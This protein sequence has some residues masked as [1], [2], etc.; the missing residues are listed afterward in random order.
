[1]SRWRATYRGD[2]LGWYD[3]AAEADSAIDNEAQR[4]RTEEEIY[5]WRD[6]CDSGREE[7][8]YGGRR[9]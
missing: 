7:V 8:Q 2:H 4:Q 3:T 9:F 1:M 5:D 6:D